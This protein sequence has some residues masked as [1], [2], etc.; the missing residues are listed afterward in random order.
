MMVGRKAS[1]V[2][3]KAVDW[4]WPNRLA[5]GVLT[6]FDGD[7]ERGKSQILATLAS[8]ITTGKPWPDGSG[9]VLGGVII[10][11]GEDSWEA[12][13]VPRLVAA[14]ADCAKVR[15]V[16]T[17]PAQDGGERLISIPEDIE[18]LERLIIEDSALLIGFDPLSAFLSDATNAN[19][20]HDVRR[21]MT[22]LVEMLE[23]TGCAGVALRHLNKQDRVPNALYRGLGSIGFNALARTVLGVAKDPEQPD[24]F[25]FSVLKN[26]LG[27]K[28]RSQ[29]YRIEGVTLTEGSQIIPTSRIVWGE[30]TDQ[31]VEDLMVAFARP[32]PRQTAKDLLLELLA[33]GPIDSKVVYQAAEDNEIS[34]KTL[35][36]AK[37][38]LGIKPKKH[39]FNPTRWTWELPAEDGQTDDSRRWPLSRSDP[40]KTNSNP[41]GRHTT[42]M[43]I[44]DE[45]SD[46]R[47]SL[48]VSDP[49]RCPDCDTACVSTGDG[50]VC[51]TCATEHD[52]PG[53]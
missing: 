7:P 1:L 36:R 32:H 33:S 35:E 50:L 11:G 29:R 17:I 38:E 42:D 40:S 30:E 27:T 49:L 37:K 4:L 2:S 43:T 10:V 21:A 8:H 6:G 22:P 34:T 16:A 26:N 48:V 28:P 44:F 3:M 14:G 18:L 41:E 12:T 51:P 47:R 25:I 23:R 53:T 13:V 20:E 5:R 46:R 45:R 15:L 39:G 19:S 9:C 24:A 31:A 52:H